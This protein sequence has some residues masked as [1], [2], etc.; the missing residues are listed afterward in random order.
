[1]KSR[2][3]TCIND[4]SKESLKKKI[5]ELEEI[6]KQKDEEIARLQSLLSL[7]KVDDQTPTNCPESPEK[8]DQKH[9]LL[10]KESNEETTALKKLKEVLEKRDEEIKKL[11][12]QLKKQDGYGTIQEPVN[13]NRRQ[14]T[15]GGI[16]QTQRKAIEGTVHQQVHVEMRQL[17]TNR[18]TV[19]EEWQDTLYNI[20]CELL[21]DEFKKL[22]SFLT[23]IPRGNLEHAE[24]L[25]V[26][27]MMIKTFG[28][29]KSITK[30]RDLMKKIP[31]NDP[32][33]QDTL[34]PFLSAIG[35]AW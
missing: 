22:K 17:H 5:T 14:D 1:M 13:M 3:S 7:P 26:A 20:L 31:R 8:D 33:V 28:F 29:N 15:S 25:D 4:E 32:V 23:E 35:E 30:T 18:I 11:K 10:E 21:E 16:S 19:K 34:T 9:P 6:S 2:L 12:K 24:R 27:E